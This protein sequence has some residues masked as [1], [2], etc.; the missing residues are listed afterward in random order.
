M[1]PDSVRLMSALEAAECI[2]SMQTVTADNLRHS[3]QGRT[4]DVNT[5]D[6]QYGYTF[7]HEGGLKNDSTALEA[8]GGCLESTS[9]ANRMAP[10]T[11]SDPQT[12]RPC[13][14][15]VVDVDW[16]LI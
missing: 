9:Y 4:V 15:K 12:C 16:W 11:D 8:S 5:Q 13:K 14:T 10:L 7:T 3:P 1:A 6:Q 2:G